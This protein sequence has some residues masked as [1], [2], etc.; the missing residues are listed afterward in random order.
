MRSLLIALLFMPSLLAADIPVSEPSQ[1]LFNQKDLKPQQI[2]LKIDLPATLDLND[3]SVELE[4]KGVSKANRFKEV[5]YLNCD[6][7]KLGAKGTIVI[8]PKPSE[9]QPREGRVEIEVAFGS[10]GKERPMLSLTTYGYRTLLQIGKKPK[11]TRIRTSVYQFNLD[12]REKV[13]KELEKKTDFQKNWQI[14]QQ[15][16]FIKRSKYE[17][18]L[19]I[20][21]SKVGL[22][23][24]INAYGLARQRFRY[25]DTLYNGMPERGLKEVEYAADHLKWCDQ[26]ISFMSD[27]Q[28]TGRLHWRAF[29]VID[30]H[31]ELIGETK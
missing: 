17:D 28:N 24:G 7:I 8:I 21:G 14:L 29:K 4:L 6:T 19:T 27:I 25:M 9:I 31:H 1:V 13:R 15:A 18:E 12:Y 20:I 3:V 23:E 26:Y 5:Q 30:G 10:Q 16:D 22:P 2:P 11:S